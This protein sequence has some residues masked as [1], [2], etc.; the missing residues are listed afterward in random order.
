MLQVFGPEVSDSGRKRVRL[1]IPM[2]PRF[3]NDIPN[4]VVLPPGPTK[5]PPFDASFN[6][7]FIHQNGHGHQNGSR[8]HQNG[9]GPHN[10]HGSYNGQGHHNGHGLQS[11]QNGYGL[12]NSVSHA[13]VNGRDY[14]VMRAA[15]GAT[16]LVPMRTPSA[17]LFR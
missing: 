12:Y 3:P 1:K 10:G 14:V 9:N 2:Q 17:L 8:G 6:V 5:P 7:P 13:N 4:M 16:Q 15:G 11:G